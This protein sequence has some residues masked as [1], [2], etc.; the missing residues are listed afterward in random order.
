MREPRRYFSPS[1]KAV[2]RLRVGGGGALAAR[3][4]R[5]GGRHFLARYRVRVRDGVHQ[6][7]FHPERVLTVPVAAWERT[8]LLRHHEALAHMLWRDEIGGDA[9]AGS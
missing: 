3:Q 6:N 8:P 7:V 9:D 2:I 1:R 5:T 4:Q